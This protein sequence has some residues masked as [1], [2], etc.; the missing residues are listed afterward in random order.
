MLDRLAGTDAA[1]AQYAEKLEHLR[2][3]HAQLAAIDALGSKEQRQRLQD[4]VNHVITP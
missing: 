4:L 1:M 3:A 2:G